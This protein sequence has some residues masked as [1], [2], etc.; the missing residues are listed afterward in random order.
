MN[1]AGGEQT[2]ADYKGVNPLKKVP[3]L[4]IDGTLLTE[5]AAI[6][7]F[8]AK[9]SPSAGLFPS[10]K[11]MIEEAEQVG[12]MSFC[13]ATL[14]PL[15]RG[16]ANPSRITDGD[17]APVR[18]RSISVA[19]TPFGYANERLAHR[20]WWLHD[21]SI[22]DVYLNWACT[23]ARSGGF[24]FHRYPALAELPARLAE[25]PAFRR[26]QEV[27]AKARQDLGL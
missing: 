21:W 16:M 13:G 2:H 4:L 25:R 18:A 10:P 19:E 17:I 3:A 14:H 22:I 26:M 6:L 9:T 12:G 27:D 15:V 1:L 24:D 23:I 5:N 20:G 7:F 11:S 8:L